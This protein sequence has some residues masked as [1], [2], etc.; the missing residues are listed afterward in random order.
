MW[1]KAGVIRILLGEK[2]TFKLAHVIL[3]SHAVTRELWEHD[4]MAG[5]D[6]EKGDFREDRGGELS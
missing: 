5:N 3:V 2:S 4:A 1:G 6:S